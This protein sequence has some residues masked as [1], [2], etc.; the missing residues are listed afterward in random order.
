[1]TCLNE[2]C[3]RPYGCQRKG[4]GGK[5]TPDGDGWMPISSEKRALYPA[6]WKEISAGIRA[7]AGNRCE[8]VDGAGRCEAVNGKPHPLTGSKVVLTTA[9]LDHNPAHCHPSNL[10]SMCQLHHL[11][12]DAAHHAKN[13]AE[14]RRKR[15][16]QTALPL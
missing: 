5:E 12:Y 10:M 4:C 1:M 2:I 6:N 8:W 7:R 3:G 9:H 16:A 14:T 13:A 11:R 15:F